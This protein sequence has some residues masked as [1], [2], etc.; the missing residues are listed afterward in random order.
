MRGNLSAQ[1][2]VILIFFLSISC[3]QLK[4]PQ[5]ANDN[6]PP[7]TTLANIPIES[8][9]LFALVNLTWD[10]EDND[11]FVV[12]YEYRYTTFPLFGTDSIHHEWIFT[13]ESGLKI[14]FCISLSIF[15]A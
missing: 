10:G 4:D 14:P 15:F 11:G 12:A 13:E 1:F 9:T 2:G 7:N 8:D 5:S 6:F 3:V